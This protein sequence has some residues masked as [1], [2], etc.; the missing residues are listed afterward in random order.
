MYIYIYMKNLCVYVHMGWGGTQWRIWFRDYY[1]RRKVSGSI[2]DEV[3]EFLQ[4][5]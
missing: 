3:I 2:P 4:L 5:S 1:T